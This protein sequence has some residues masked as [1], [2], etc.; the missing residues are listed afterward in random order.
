[1]DFF[2]PAHMISQKLRRFM[3]TLL[4]HQIPP[5]ISMRS[6]KSRTVQFEFLT[7]AL[8]LISVW[9]SLHRPAVLVIGLLKQLPSVASFILLVYFVFGHRHFC[10]FMHMLS[11][12]RW[13]R[14]ASSP[15]W[16]G[17]PWL[18]TRRFAGAWIYWDFGVSAERHILWCYVT[19]T[20]TIDGCLLSLTI[21][22]W[23]P[24]ER[25]SISV[26]LLYFRIVWYKMVLFTARMIR[27]AFCV[28]FFCIRYHFTVP[29]T[30]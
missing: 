16:T 10:P 28:I 13:R 8:T 4:P 15:V 11:I 3:L 27:C 18:Y 5:L 14:R 20:V 1:M 19:T 23:M 6:S 22:L 25:S 30:P 24:P 29:Y 7:L 9:E 21:R 2:G 17:R 12:R 26:L